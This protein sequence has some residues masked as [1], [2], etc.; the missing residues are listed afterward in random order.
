MSLFFTLFLLQTC[1]AQKQEACVP[2]SCG[3]ITNIKHPFRLKHDPPNYGNPSYELACENNITVLNLHSGRYY[4]ESINYNNFTIRLVDPGVQQNDCS[5]TPRYFLYKAN[6]SYS[7][8]ESGSDAYEYD[9]LFEHVIYLNCS[10]L[11]SD[12]PEYVDTASCLN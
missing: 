10:N 11:V 1:I 8:S 7:Y 4:V 3:K 5:S 6:F 2:S 9:D 12:D